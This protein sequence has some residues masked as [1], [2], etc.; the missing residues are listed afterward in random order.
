MLGLWR[1]IQILESW[2][3]GMGNVMVEQFITIKSEALTCNICT[4]ALCVLIRLHAKLTV[5][6][7]MLSYFGF[8]NFESIYGGIL[9]SLKGVFTCNGCSISLD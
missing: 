8:C 2:L 1:Y 6:S 7:F 9:W 4:H 5:F 3:S